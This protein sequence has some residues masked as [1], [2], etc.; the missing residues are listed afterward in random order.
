MLMGVHAVSRRD[1]TMR[2]MIGAC[3]V[4]VYSMAVFPHNGSTPT[5]PLPLQA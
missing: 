4:T 3:T 5:P 2:L 1:D